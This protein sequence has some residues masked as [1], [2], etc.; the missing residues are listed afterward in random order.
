MDAQ[1]SALSHFSKRAKKYDRSSNW[2]DDE[3]LIAKI[4]GLVEVSAKARVLDIAVGTGKIARSFRGRVAYIIGL[5]ICRDMAKQAGECADKMVLTPAEKMPFKN[6]AFDA[7]VCR[8]G[9][10]F[11]VLDDVLAEIH[12]VL[13]PGGRAVLCH[14]TAYGTEDKDETFLIQ[15]FRNPARKNFFLPQDIPAALKK[16]NFTS[17]ESFE[18]ITRESVEQWIDNGAID[19]SQKERIREVY[20]NASEAFLEIHN[21]GFK[22]GD[23]FDSMKMVI[24][25]AMKG[26]ADE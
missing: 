7:C 20:R 16:A 25:R 14:L 9:L 17:I 10:Q 21:I 15:K 6:G 19:E 11:M 26:D 5:D 4:R 24:V 8:Q 12:R 3:V 22:N 18:Y 23:I 1:E 2:V 13:K